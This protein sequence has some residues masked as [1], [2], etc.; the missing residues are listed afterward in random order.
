MREQEHPQPAEPARDPLRDTVPVE[1]PAI[2]DAAPPV[3]PAERPEM[4]I[5]TGMSGA[6][7]SR[8]A[9][10]LEDLDWYV[11]DNLPPQ[12]LPALA[13]M[14]TT[15]GAGVHRLAA[16]VD[17]RSREFFAHFME[18]LRQVRGAGTEVR[19]IFLDASDAALV[20][21]FESSRRP[22]PLQGTASVLEGIEHERTLLAGL[23]GMADIVIDTSRYSVHELARRVRE[24]V[25]RESDLALRVHVMSFGF[26]YGLPL[27]AD[28][29]VDVRFIPNPF[30]VSELRHLTGRDAAVADYVFAQDGAAPFV[31]GY[32]DLLAPALPH[33]VDELKPHVTIAVGCTGGKHRSV[34]SAERIGSR[35]RQAG[36]EVV[37]QHRDL[38]RE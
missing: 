38:G 16:V 17:V 25:A 37:V 29:V 31:D 33:Y 6:G 4:I 1:I 28:H 14:M 32:A 15:V 12:L 5:V 10:A 21:R 34:A 22:H 2:D 7:R 23:K 35:L 18:Y 13:G 3:P 24:L 8:A 36:F 30:W 11:V 20:R 27:D 9:D 19:L 26:K